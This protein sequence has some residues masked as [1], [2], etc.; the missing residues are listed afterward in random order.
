MYH[1]T[2]FPQTIGFMQDLKNLLSIY[3]LIE[4]DAEFAEAIQH[5]IDD[6]RSARADADEL[7]RRHNFV[8]ANLQTLEHDILRQQ[9]EFHKMSISKGDRSKS[10]TLG[11]VA[12]AGT[13]AG[14][15]V[16]AASLASTGATTALG[17]TAGASGFEALF[18]SAAAPVV[19]PL[20]V[21]GGM[22]GGLA[23][24]LGGVATENGQEAARFKAA[25]ISTKTLHV[26]LGGFSEIVESGSKLLDQIE[27]N[28]NGMDTSAKRAKMKLF[29]K[30]TKR[31]IGTVLALC[32]EFISSRQR[33]EVKLGAIRENVKDNFRRDWQ[34]RLTEFK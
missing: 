9:R 13:A 22:I 31:R 4:N 29:L 33:F 15:G 10:A 6:I 27:Q 23:I 12:M 5:H 2:V 18:V 21:V 24:A 3:P 26:S 30:D 11:S 19:W 20:L 16:T 7:R 1:R 14:C 25:A 28:L 32:E 34:R 17:F 8:L